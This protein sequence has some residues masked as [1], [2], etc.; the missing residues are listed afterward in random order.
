MFSNRELN[1]RNLSFNSEELGT[2]FSKSYIIY[3]WKFNL[4]GVQRIITLAHSRIKGKRVITLDKKEICNFM[5]YTYR[6]S[7]EFS[8]DSHTITINQND[9]GY[10]LKIDGINFQKLINQQKLE[11][12]NIIREEYIKEH[13]IIIE[14]PKEEEK[15]EEIKEEQIDDNF[16]E[17]KEEEDE[18]FEEKEEEKE[19][20]EEE[21]D[22][23]EEKE[24]EDK[25]I[26]TTDLLQ[27]DNNE[28]NKINSQSER[29][30]IDN[31]NH[32]DLLGPEI[33]NSAKMSERNN[34][35]NS[36]LNIE[37]MLNNT[38]NNNK[39]INKQNII[40][41]TEENEENENTNRNENPIVDIFNKI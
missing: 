28:D 13:P 18:E 12:Y 16:E 23:E 15:K 29:T 40:K 39:E 30:I 38:N 1:I 22:K 33:F 27:L 9:E 25:K 14:K 31:T 11:R 8:I 10:I 2:F 7:Y 3:T 41:N 21:E 26:K 35:I 17:V 32:L 20:E 5:K 19:K 6:F 4:D 36:N 24:I 37:M 34:D